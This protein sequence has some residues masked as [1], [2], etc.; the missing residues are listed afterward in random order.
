MFAVMHNPGNMSDAEMLFLMAIVAAVAMIPMIG[1]ALSAARFVLK[2]LFVGL[3]IAAGVAVG[4]AVLD[5]LRRNR[6]GL[7]GKNANP[8]F[9]FVE[10]IALRK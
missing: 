8:V 4:G 10:K 3:L 9:D 5:Y 2:W 7:I 6:Y 1:M